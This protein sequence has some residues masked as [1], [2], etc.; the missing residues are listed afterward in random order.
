MTTRTA[1]LRTAAL[2]LT[3]LVALAG[4]GT[5]KEIAYTYTKANVTEVLLLGTR[6][7]SNAP[8]AW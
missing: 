4:C 7:C 5:R 1:F 8:M 6:R 2:S 3:A